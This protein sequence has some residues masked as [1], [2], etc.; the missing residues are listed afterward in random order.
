MERSSPIVFFLHQNPPSL[1]SFKNHMHYYMYIVITYFV[2]SLSLSLASKIYCVVKII[3]IGMNH[4]RCFTHK[5][6]THIKVNCTVGLELQQT[7]DVR[8]LQSLAMITKFNFRK[9]R[10]ITPKNCEIDISLFTLDALS[11]TLYKYV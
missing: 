2:L 1:S 10:K 9:N 7:S 5:I 8:V 11:Y 3:D 6:P 4:L